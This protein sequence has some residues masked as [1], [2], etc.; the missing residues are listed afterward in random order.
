MRLIDADKLY[1]E[2]EQI[3]SCDYG[4]IFSYEAHNAASDVLQD[5]KVLIENAPTIKTIERI[6]PNEAN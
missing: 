3:N 4:S 1:E 6:K 2:I 5:I